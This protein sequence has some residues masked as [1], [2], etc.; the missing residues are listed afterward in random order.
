MV[1]NFFQV[2]GNQRLDIYMNTYFVSDFHL[3]LPFLDPRAREEK[4]VRFFN[5]IQSTASDIYLLGDIFDFWFE[6]KTVV[7][8]GFV[9]FLGKLAALSDAGVRV[10]FLAGNHDAWAKEYLTE[11]CGVEVIHGSRTLTI[12]GKNFFLAHGDYLGSRSATEKILHRI[13]H[14][15]IIQKLFGSLHPRWGV[16]FGHLWSRHSR[17]AKGIAVPFR[18]E[19][20]NLYQFALQHSGN[21]AIDYFIFGHRHTP[22]AMQLPTGA[23]LVILSDWITDSTYVVFDGEQVRVER[24]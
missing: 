3:G 7:P 6:Y 5:S 4:V 24:F 8:R 10:H 15:R 16:G 19:A 2:I 12:G 1:N 18:G 13:F 23:Q 14:N 21:N 20:E 17:A 11:E 22:I 9:R